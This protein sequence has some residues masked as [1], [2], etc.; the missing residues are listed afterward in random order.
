MSTAELIF[1]KLKTLPRVRADDR[2]C[3]SSRNKR[4]TRSGEVVEIG[5]VF[6]APAGLLIPLKIGQRDEPDRNAIQFSGDA[7]RITFGKPYAIDAG[8]DFDAVWR[9]THA[10]DTV[11]AEEQVGDQFGKIEPELF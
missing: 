7:L 11:I 9:S 10:D 2:C 8:L 5:E 6:I 4:P 3:R 1:A